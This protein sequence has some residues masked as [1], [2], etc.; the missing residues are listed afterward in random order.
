MRIN[1][2]AVLAL[3]TLC[4]AQSKME[5]PVRQAVRGVHGAI[6]AGSEFATEAG[7]HTYYKGGNAVDAGVSTMFAGS[8]TEL[9]HYG[10]GVSEKVVTDLCSRIDDDVRQQHSVPTDSYILTDH[11]VWTNVSV[12]ADLGGWV[13]YRRGVDPRRIF[14]RLVK[15]FD[16]LCES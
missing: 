7:M 6:A 14:R 12:F 2:L 9:S 5:R 10:M 3:A 11:H 4:A 13:N 15:K 8:V 1:C 16:C